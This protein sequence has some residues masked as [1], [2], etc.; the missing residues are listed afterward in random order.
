MWWTEVACIADTVANHPSLAGGI[1]PTASIDPDAVLDISNGPIAIGAGSRI[2][3]GAIVRGPVVIGAGCLIGHRALIRGAALIGNRV[4]IGYTAEIKTSVVRDGCTIGPLCFVGDS[5]LE[6]EVYLGALVRTSNQRLDRRAIQTEHDG[7]M[8]DTGLDKLGC[9][10]GARSALGIQVVV[11]PGRVIA[12]DSMFE[13][14]VTVTRNLP[15]GRYRAS[16]TLEQVH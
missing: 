16:Q 15:P 4:R 3:P 6:P 11:L 5:V 12:P 9:W 14:R 2:C 10:I 1:D 13:P 8:L 7:A